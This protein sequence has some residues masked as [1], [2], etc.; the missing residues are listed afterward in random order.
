M[1]RP[2]L[3]SVPALIAVLLLR[4]S[5]G[6]PAT[7]AATTAFPVLAAAHVEAVVLPPPPPTDPPTTS[8]TEAPT[9]TTTEAPTTAPATE[10]P[11]TEPSTEAPSTTAKRR[12]ARPT[13]TAPAE[14]P[15]PGSD[16]PATDPPAT[17]APAPVAIHGDASAVITLTNE[18]RAAA[19]LGPLSPNSALHTAAQRESDDMAENLR[20]SHTGSD[21]STVGTRATAAGYSWQLIGE[22]IAV[23]YSSASSVM[24]GWMASAG[25]RANILNASFV[26]IGVAVSTGSDGRKYWTMV[27]GA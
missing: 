15:T 4:G 5:D 6:T 20:M 8:T 27:L 24:D 13:T 9:T 10:A 16:P 18:Q 14:S 7:P 21:G 25:H 1:L 3:L 17:D 2:T 19:G 11:T 23:G 22:N 26:D 12:K